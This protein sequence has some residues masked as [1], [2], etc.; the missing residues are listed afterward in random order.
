[1]MSFSNA[2]SHAFNN[3]QASP[4]FTNSF[5][6]KF[7]RIDTV[8]MNSLGDGIVFYPPSG[9]P[10]KT[11][12][13]LSARP[14]TG[15][16]P[17]FEMGDNIWAKIDIYSTPIE[18]LENA[19]PGISKSWTVFYKGATYAISEVIY[20]GNNT[21]LLILYYPGNTKAKMGGWR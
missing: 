8:I 19:V 12:C 3:V 15:N 4:S 18:V 2:F 7:A 17:G 5:D 9:E 16:K 21:L 10:I 6:Q 20:R 13:I 11:K 1:V 14:N